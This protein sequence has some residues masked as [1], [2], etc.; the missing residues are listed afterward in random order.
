MALVIALAGLLLASMVT[1]GPASHPANAQSADSSIDFAENG[2]GPAGTFVA[3]DQDGDAIE[4][5]LSG[6]DAD[7]FTI[8]GGV[9]SFREP[10]DYEDPQSA[11]AVEKRA[12]RNVYRV[13]IEASGGMHHVAVTVTDVD[14]AG[15]VSI[16]RPQ[17]Q[18]DRPLGAALSDE[19]EVVTA[20]RWQWARS[21]GG[22]T[23]TDIEGATSPRRP[24]VPDD[25]GMYLRATVTYS[26]RFGSGKTASAV[27]AHRVEAR[28]LSNAA[29]YFAE[30]DAN[31]DT[32]YI[33]VARSVAENTA[34]GMN[35][36]RTVSAT[37]A[38]A[39]ILFYE[40][41]DT[42]DLRDDD[43]RAR[44]TIDSA[45]GQVRVGR[46]LGADAGEREDEDSS[47]LSGD[48]SLPQ[49][50]DAGEALNGEYILRVRVSD[51]STAFATVNVIVTVTRVNEAP[52]F[53][54]EDVPTVL[55]VRENAD[56]PVITF[57]DSDTPVVVD[58]YAV[59]DQDGSVGGAH[60]YD[61]TAY[62]YSVSGPDSDVLAFD[63]TGILSFRAGHEP[64]YEERS[65]YSITVL[66]RSGEGP[67]G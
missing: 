2:T 44:F 5:S 33:D 58:T 22:T 14:E 37:D 13:T 20:E 53:V 17:P 48:P 28:T 55:R 8:D 4:W 64:D 1:D 7:R 36:G 3:Y 40:L 54:G 66:A 19:D 45:S 29:P 11:A 27:S 50:E 10:P 42:P 32:P 57:G 25:V 52:L 38:D 43:G 67:A 23:W 6:P 34:V 21:E 41:V 51:P 47:S 39:D 49:D 9:L 26:D 31:E 15:T 61:D 35:V 65:S 24:P 63:A 46:E 62:A 56:P 16:D 12:E 59:T 30:Q 18:V 60:P